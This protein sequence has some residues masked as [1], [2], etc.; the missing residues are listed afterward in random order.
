MKKIKKKI[1]KQSKK[2]SLQE[3]HRVWPSRCCS[4]W[5][6]L[7]LSWC[8]D[9]INSTL[10][11]SDA[12]LLSSCVKHGPMEYTSIGYS[13]RFNITASL[14]KFRLWYNSLCSLRRREEGRRKGRKEKLAESK[15]Q[16]ERERECVCVYLFLLFLFCVRPRK[17]HI[18]S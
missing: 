17:V 15:R 6:A 16:R 12:S 13:F 9:G 10:I 18:K 3:K 14:F 4:P 5:C 8:W 2:N 1:I 11:I 7:T